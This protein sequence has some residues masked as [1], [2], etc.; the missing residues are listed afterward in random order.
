[1]PAD[2]HDLPALDRLTADVAQ[3]MR[4]AE[5]APRPRWW[6][7]LPPL[8]V[9]L[10]ALAV[11]SAVV[12][13]AM[14]DDSEGATVLPVPALHCDGGTAVGAAMLLTGVASVARP[15]APL[16]SRRVDLRAAAPAR[17]SCA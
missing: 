3:A 17:R 10:L 8:T 14:T 2:R 9:T 13:H 11:P 5:R 6:R 12:L 7:R 15:D 4:A 16:L 1:M